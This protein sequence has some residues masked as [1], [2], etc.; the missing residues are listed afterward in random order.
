M[1]EVKSVNSRCDCLLLQGV[2]SYIDKDALVPEN[3]GW[4]MP[5]PHSLP[6][7]HLIPQPMIQLPI[8]RGC[9]RAKGVKL[10]W[11]AS[12]KKPAHRISYHWPETGKG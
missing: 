1:C 3:A 8:L 5:H 2:V 9:C 10:E 7:P 11:C 4:I 6:F 12:A